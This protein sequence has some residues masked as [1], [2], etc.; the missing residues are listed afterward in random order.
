MFES[1]LAPVS[2]V[3]P[4][5][6]LASLEVWDLSL[7]RSRHRRVLAVRHR[8]SAQKTKGTAA[9][10]SAALLVSPVLPFATGSAQ[11]AGEA[12]SAPP[13]PRPAKSGVFVERGDRG[14]T[15]AKVQRALRISADGVFGP[16]TERAVKRFQSRADLTR[17]GIVGPNTWRTLMKSPAPAA[18]ETEQKTAK[19]RSVSVSDPPA[20]AGTC[21]GPISAPVQGT[22]LGGFGDG[23]NHA[24]ADIEAPVG[25]PV[26]AA[27]CGTVTF[28]GT[29]SGYGRM[30]C[31]QHSSSFSTC[32]AHL[33]VRR[34][35]KGDRVEAGQ[36]IGRAGMTG[37]SSGPHVHFETRVN[38]SPVNPA[39]YLAGESV[40]P[41]TEQ[42][43]AAAQGGGEVRAASASKKASARDRRA[44]AGAPKRRA[45]TGGA[46][47]PG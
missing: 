23:R 15:V 36:V 42:S 18:S 26:H 11:A 5:R 25:T 44:K 6:D 34:V 32:Y 22:L 40:I 20:A 28:A 30:I 17:D 21:G 7:N 35:A 41:G 1:Y 8:Q 29:E 4:H 38:G 46:S 2:G 14:K 3:A 31:V 13:L 37:R 10:V 47:A 43:D 39:P 12:R 9:A 33:S 45:T 27:G 19:N 16:M 24:G